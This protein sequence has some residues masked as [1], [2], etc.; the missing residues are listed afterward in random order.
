VIASFVAASAAQA[1]SVAR[2]TPEAAGFDGEG[3]GKIG[4]AIN[5]YIQRGQL[6]GASVLIARHGKVVYLES[7]GMRDVER[8]LPMTAD[9]IVRF[10]SMTKP[11]TAAAAMIAE[12]DG[13]FQL[14]DPVAK[15]V[16][17]LAH[18]TVYQSG[19]G[20]QIV[21]TPATKT[22]TIENLLTHTSG[23]S[24]SFQLGTPVSALYPKVGLS[25]GN[26]FQN[27]QIKGLPDMATRLATIP[28]AFEP[29]EKWHYGMS[30]D[31][32][33][34]VIERASHMPF[35]DFVRQ[36]L[37]VPLGMSDTDFIVPDT[38]KDRFASLYLW[39]N[40]SRVLVEDSQKSPFLNPPYAYTGSGGL[41]GT[42][43]DYWHFAQML[44]NGG[45]FNGVRVLPPSA[46]DQMLSDHL[47]PDQHG[48]LREAA[49]FGIGGDGSGLGFGYGGA[50]VIDSSATGGSKGE[51][52][53]GGAASTTFFV[54]RKED[55]VAVLIT[56]VLPSGAFPLRDN[57]K[58]LVY[59][60]LLHPEK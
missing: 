58:T 22:M 25:A 12:A 60:A 40:S 23:F 38:K 46:V 37:L 5:G 20:D 1:S 6:A 45:T 32:M 19:S 10:Y 43:T 27:P 54:D 48:Q 34:L 15:Y 24:Y 9:T 53:W 36:R 33:G 51:Y 13:D 28:L 41:L 52:S 7:F 31:V 39:R 50:I 8:H 16:P 42:I 21:T 18:L 57:L 14:S 44:C 56:Q 35:Q 29:G 2:T 11:L 47:R 4:E 17:E 30:L 26:W 59:Q 49:S 55:I 3:L